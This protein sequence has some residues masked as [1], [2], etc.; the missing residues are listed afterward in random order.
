[1]TDAADRMPAGAGAVT[2]SGQKSRDAA[3]AAGIMSP[4]SRPPQNGVPSSLQTPARDPAPEPTAEPAAVRA[5]VPAPP[6][7]ATPTPAPAPA[8]DH[9]GTLAALDAL[10]DE[11]GYF[12]RLGPDHAALFLDEG[13]VLLVTFETLS[14]IAAT[15]GGLPLGWRVAKARGWSCL[16]L[17]SQRDDWYRANPVFGFFDRQVDDAFFEDFDRVVFW[18][19]G[20]GG[21]AAAAFSA[22][23]PG[24][25][26]LLAAPQATLDPR[27]TGWDARFRDSRRTAFDTRYGY[28]PDMIDGAGPVYLVYDPEQVLDAM[29][30]SL[31][32]RPFVTKLPCPLIGAD[33]GGML[34]EMDLLEPLLVAA[35]DGSFTA[36]RFWSGYRQARRKYGPWLRSLAGRMTE[37]GRPVLAAMVLRNGAKRL[38]SRRM[39]RQAEALAAELAEAGITLPKALPDTL[40]A[41]PPETGGR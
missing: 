40:P 29:H 2:A 34:A 37:R 15:P 13:P 36:A 3:L 39:R 9:A 18:G 24:A 11:A 27:I 41:V 5:P 8:E 25:T 7:A 19:A 21:Y 14:S 35:C 28:A 20:R 33:P 22:T 31:F 30:A 1:M 16:C 17:V 10:G 23:A 12:E 26:V 32:T 6:P 4:R 38:N